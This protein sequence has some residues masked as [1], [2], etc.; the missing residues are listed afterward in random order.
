MRTAICP[1][2]FDPVTFGHLDIIGR[3]SLIFDRVIV[4]VSRNPIKNPL[5]SI[6]ERVEMLK[7]VL[8]PYTNVEVDSFEG[9]TVNYALKQKAKA[10]VRGLRVIS[11]F[12]NEFRMA[13]TNK[14]LACH[15]ET[16][17]LMTRAE[18]S[19][20]SSSTVKEVASF[21]GSVRSLVPPL[22]EERLK[23]KLKSLPS[24]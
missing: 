12:E 3:A 7:G 18:F 19:F 9:L 16:V 20:I 6:E 5:F 24:C 2:S 8:A 4:A 17:F 10:I 13:L 15:V 22:V 23:E 11:D 1:G 14:K 21:G